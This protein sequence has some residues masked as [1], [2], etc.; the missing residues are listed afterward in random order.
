MSE[1][2]D[3]LLLSSDEQLESKPDGYFRVARHE[4]LPYVPKSAKTILD[5][6]CASGVFGKLLKENRT[7]EVW[8]V[9]PNTE[10]AEA[11]K[12]SLDRVICDNFSHNLDIPT[13]Y[14]DC[15]VFNDVLE[16]LVDP[17]SA[18]IYSKKLLKHD[19][20]V[21]AS[22]PNVRYFPNIW[23]L[24]IHKDWEYKEA[25]ILDKTHLRF[26]TKKSTISTFCQSGY[27]VD[28]IVGINSLAQLG[29][30][31]KRVFKVFNFVTFNQVE[32]MKYQQFSVVASLRKETD[33]L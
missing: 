29:S 6:G 14:F 8:G 17:I 28:Q 31:L 24:M 2:T 30:P 32:D 25:G 3:L 4:M 33:H 5:V 11:A 7:A 20:C 12:K 13:E 21:V 15:I 26:F 16:H 10:A 1:R 27:E 22:I 19:G 9:E 18:L 23:E